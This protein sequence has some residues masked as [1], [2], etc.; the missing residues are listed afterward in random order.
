MNDSDD[1][2]RNIEIHVKVDLTGMPVDKRER[3]VWFAQR[4]AAREQRHRER[5]RALERKDAEAHEARHGIDTWLGDKWWEKEMTSDELILYRE[6]RER[7]EKERFAALV[8][9]ERERYRRN[10]S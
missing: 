2:S 4:K 8:D 5:L 7:I 6:D 9:K 1:I 10:D 3:E